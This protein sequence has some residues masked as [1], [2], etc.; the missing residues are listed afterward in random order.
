MDP[1]AARNKTMRHDIKIG[2]RRLSPTAARKFG[3]VRDISPNGDLV[4]YVE[5]AGEFVIAPEAVEAVHSGKVI[6][7][8]A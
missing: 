6:L 7:R 2:S 5:N 4:I 1:R 3:A 8:C